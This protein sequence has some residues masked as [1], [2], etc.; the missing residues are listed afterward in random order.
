MS[1]LDSF[2][3]QLGFDI[4]T[5]KIAEFRG[6]ADALKKSVLE[7]GAVFIGASAGL[8]LLVHS[9]AES[10]G[11]IQDFAELN[12][13]S[14][15]SVAALGKIATANDSSVEGLQ[16]TLQSLTRQA[17]EAA[18]GIGRATIIFQKL[19][20]AA[21]NSDGTVKK[22]DQLLGE[23]ADKMQNLSRQEQIG[24]AAKLG[25]DAPLVKLLSQGGDNLAKLREEAELFNPFTDADYELAE[26]VD[27]LFTKAK[28]SVGV[29]AKIIGVSLLP[30]AREVLTTYL[31]WF[32]ASRKATSGVV[33]EGVQLFVAVLTAAWEWVRRVTFGIRDLGAWLS[34]FKVITYGAVVALGA[35]VSVQAYSAFVQLTGALKLLIINLVRFNAAA[36]FVPAVLGAIGLAVALLIDDYANFR[37]GN[38]SMIA[39]LGAKFPLVLAVIHALE[40]AVSGFVAAVGPPIIWLV[41]AVGTVLAA[42][43]DVAVSAIGGAF[44]F[45]MR[46]AVGLRNT[47]VLLS[48]VML[49]FLAQVAV[50]LAAQGVQWLALTAR[51]VAYWAVTQTGAIAA[52]AAWVASMVAAGAATWIALLPLLAIG[53]ALAATVATAWLFYDNWGTIT[54]ALSAA[55]TAFADGIKSAF[56]GAIDYVMELIQ[57]AQDAT[58]KLLSSIPGA[59]ILAGAFGVSLEAPGPAPGPASSTSWAPAS[60]GR[61]VLGRADTGAMNSTNASSTSTTT[62]S[63]GSVVIQSPDPERAGVAFRE[64]MDRQNRQSMRNGQSAVDL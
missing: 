51:S 33:V 15:R 2:F 4:N 11:A 40:A 8:A 17:G 26:K 47:V 50:A 14:A 27:K 21:K 31:E 42:A 46:H 60:A 22:A 39:E 55:W 44:A 24:M 23:I 25:I 63:P 61:G 36:L 64:E 29:F 10:M 62:F 19:G 59:S 16:S 30:V 56:S 6:Q 48:V 12:E 5:E 41:N 37:E 3:V 49:P 43:F 28:D 9:V 54:G 13:L 7:V 20:I 18:L 35:F 1:V 45:L 52:G 53:L 32:K 57:R 34:Q 58:R 38:A